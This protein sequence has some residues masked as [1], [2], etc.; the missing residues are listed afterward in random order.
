MR[1]KLFLRVYFILVLSVVP[2]TA[3]AEDPVLNT[4]VR[5]ELDAAIFEVLSEYAPESLETYPPGK[6]NVLQY[7]TYKVNDTETFY[8]QLYGYCGHHCYWIWLFRDET[9]SENIKDQIELVKFEYPRFN[10][11]W[12]I[13]YDWEDGVGIHG[14]SQDG[15]LKN[16]IIK[17]RWGARSVQKRYTWKFEKGVGFKLIAF[18]STGYPGTI[19]ECDVREY[20]LKGKRLIKVGNPLIQLLNKFF[21]DERYS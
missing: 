8:Q 14:D 5:S 12:L 15:I 4:E 2:L 18:E 20:R 9:K 11:G 19:N 17:V 1:I 10:D 6:K 13:R 21:C 3:W 16:G 7:Y